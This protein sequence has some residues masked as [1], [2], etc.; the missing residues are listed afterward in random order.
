ML[1]F[2]A[3]GPKFTLP[4][5]RTAAAAIGRYLLPAPDL[6]S[7]PAAAAAVDRRDRQM[8]GQTLDRFMTLTVY[9]HVC[10]TP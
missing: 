10:H 8:D 4:A 1:N 5:C 3:V 9:Y 6:S 7:K 2:L